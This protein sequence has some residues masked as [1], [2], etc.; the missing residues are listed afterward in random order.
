MRW[1]IVAVVDGQHDLLAVCESLCERGYDRVCCVVVWC[2][3][4]FCSYG[5]SGVEK[6]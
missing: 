5:V 3:V 4:V 1:W 2:G 6:W